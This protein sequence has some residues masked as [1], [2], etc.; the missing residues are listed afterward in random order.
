MEKAKETSP[1]SKV[2]RLW[3]EDYVLWH[4]T[5][6]CIIVSSLKVFC[7]CPE[8]ISWQFEWPNSCFPQT[9]FKWPLWF[10]INNKTHA[11]PYANFILTSLSF[12]FICRFYFHSV[13]FY[14]FFPPPPNVMSTFWAPLQLISFF[15]DHVIPH[16]YASSS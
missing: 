16:K 6:E 1:H 5:R 7:F 11:I 10:M 9:K 4:R 8:T 14:V 13:V 2:C 12:S 15:F 3:E